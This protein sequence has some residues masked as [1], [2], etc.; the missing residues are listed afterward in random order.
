M[1]CRCR[2]TIRTTDKPTK[3]AAQSSPLSAVKSEATASVTPT[4]SVPTSSTAGT[5]ATAA[6][7]AAAANLPVQTLA[8]RGPS[9]NVDQPAAAGPITARPARARRAKRSTDAEDAAPTKRC[10][11]VTHYGHVAAVP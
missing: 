1:R 10:D 9:D 5:E 11:A 8:S 3:A 2:T 4:E 7:A 6:A